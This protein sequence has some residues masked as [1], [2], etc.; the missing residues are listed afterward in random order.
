[1]FSI[2]NYI[3]A[4]SSYDNDTGWL[5]YLFGIVFA[6]LVIFGA[7]KTIVDE[8]S[9]SD[10]KIL[11]KYKIFSSNYKAKPIVSEDKGKLIKRLVVCLEVEKEKM[12]DSLNDK[13]E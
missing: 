2:T 9:G 4:V 1:M 12:R 6:I 13:K 5:F 10:I 11:N 8:F 7:I 3:L